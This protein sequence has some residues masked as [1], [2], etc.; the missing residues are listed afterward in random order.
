MPSSS[1]RPRMP[2]HL[3]IGEIRVVQAQAEQ[4]AMMQK[5]LDQAE[6]SGQCRERQDY[7]ESSTGYTEISINELE[8]HTDEGPKNGT[9]IFNGAYMSAPVVVEMIA[10]D[11]L[12]LTE[13]R[14]LTVITERVSTSPIH[15]LPGHTS[16]FIL[17]VCGTLFVCLNS[18]VSVTSSLVSE[19]SP[20]RSRSIT[21]WKTSA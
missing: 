7:L 12:S 4:Q 20:L 5:I 17:D 8:V 9:N 13:I 11:Q 19:S 16:H 15:L 2:I 3:R 18:C 10:S 21:S 14:R 6:A 1:F